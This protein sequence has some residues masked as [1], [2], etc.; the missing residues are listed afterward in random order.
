VHEQLAEQSA[1]D[2]DGGGLHA[3]EQHGAVP[4]VAEQVEW[5]GSVGSSR[6][7][8]CFGSRGPMA[9]ISAWFSA[10]TRSGNAA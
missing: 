9:S 8:S 10:D 3:I 1:A 6:S 5:F 4:V 2:T 7:A